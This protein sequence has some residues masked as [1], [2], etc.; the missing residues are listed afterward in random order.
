MSVPANK[1]KGISRN[2]NASGLEAFF[3]QN[4]TWLKKVMLI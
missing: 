3:R 2:P 4:K 1:L